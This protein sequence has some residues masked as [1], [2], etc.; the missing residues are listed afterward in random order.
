MIASLRPSKLLILLV[1]SCLVWIGIIS[2]VVALFFGSGISLGWIVA[3]VLLLAALIWVAVMFREFRGA[4]EIPEYFP[5]VKRE[6][7]PPVP[8]NY[9]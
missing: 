4:I 2:F 1:F 5:P 9:N 7:R 8:V 3:G 6:A